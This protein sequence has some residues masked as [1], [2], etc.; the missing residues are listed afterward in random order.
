M[1]MCPSKNQ[2]RPYEDNTDRLQ[3]AECA[4][5][6]PVCVSIIHSFEG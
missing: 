1:V 5:H 4:E 2:D 6:S 3:D